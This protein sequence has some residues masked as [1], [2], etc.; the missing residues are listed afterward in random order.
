MKR[1]LL[2]I[3]VL[4][5]TACNNGGKPEKGTQG[6]NSV[7]NGDNTP[8]G[9]LGEGKRLIASYDCQTCHMPATKLVGPSFMDISK[10]YPNAEGPA[11]TLARSIVSGS[12]GVWD[13]TVAMPAHP[14]I[15][16]N[17]A[18]KMTRYILSLSP[19]A[20]RDSMNAVH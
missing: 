1:W 10:R 4:V 9:E 20:K 15:N 14:N 2:F 6:D 16:L 11:Q 18:L 3:S 19:Q 17:D 13:T 8:A 12:K 7:V 5:L